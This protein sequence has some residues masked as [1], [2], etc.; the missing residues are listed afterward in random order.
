MLQLDS[1]GLHSVLQDNPILEDEK[2]CE[3]NIRVSVEEGGNTILQ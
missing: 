3:K 2:F 1:V